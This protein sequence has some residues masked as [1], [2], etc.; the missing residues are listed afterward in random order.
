M[1][2]VSNRGLSVILKDSAAEWMFAK[3]RAWTWLLQLKDSCLPPNRSN[4][5]SSGITANM[6]WKE[7]WRADPSAKDNRKYDM[8]TS[9][10]SGSPTLNTTSQTSE[11]IPSS[12]LRAFV[13][14]R[15]LPL[16]LSF[17]PVLRVTKA[18]DPHASWKWKMMVLCHLSG[19]WLTVSLR[20]P[21]LWGKMNFHE[22]KQTW[23]ALLQ[24]GTK[25]GRRGHLSSLLRCWLVQ[26]SQ[27]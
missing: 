22:G 5:G 27:L 17:L 15:E 10:L 13:S 24:V 8:G 21:K 4:S 11:G 3:T 23:E 26:K 25:L 18:R 14:L 1:C 20:T 12:N 7:S 16:I 9:Q 2:R 6:G 19:Q